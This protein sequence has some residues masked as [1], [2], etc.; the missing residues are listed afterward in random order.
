MKYF[1]LALASLAG[2]LA[3]WPAGAQAQ[4]ELVFVG[5]GK[6]NIESF[7][8][9]PGTGALT[10]IGTAAELANPSFLSIAPNH[11]F[12]YAI[13]EGQSEAR[14]N[15]NA[16]AIDAAAGKLTFLN[17]QPAGGTVT[18]YVEFD[19]AGK[20]ALIANYGSG[21]FA[22][23]PLAANGELQPVS[24]FMQ[25]KGS[26]TNP[27]RQS[28]PHAHCI[29]VAPGDKFVFGCD[30]GTDKVMSFKFDPDK[31][32]LVPNEP[33]FAPVK[34]GFGSRHIAFHP[35]S[36]W[37]YVISEMGST[38]TAFSYDASAGALHEI[39]V[40]STLP[41]GFS[42]RSTC[43]EVAVHPNG[44]AVYGSNR[45]D[46]SIAVYSC[47]PETGRLTFLQRMPTGG[48]TPR[49]FE[50][51][52]TGRW[53]LAANQQSNTVVV[54]SI[55]PATG[56]LKPTGIEAPSDTPECVRFLMAP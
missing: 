52:L 39:Q 23:F 28:G 32:T 48:K 44:K 45:G 46:D 42:G 3:L 13:N 29:V 1:H 10:K 6:Q 49:N 35:N 27:G 54:F 47:D 37:A 34:A 31:G 14:C 5:S 11:K 41:E 4:Q 51:D 43:A 26:S 18:C 16:Y 15:V 12:L 8:F 33:A 19:S 50:I 9:D 7:R 53:L 38:I 55:D 30:L 40:I 2:A 25:D 21:S 36:R 24:A 56:Q 20:N 17:K 22:V